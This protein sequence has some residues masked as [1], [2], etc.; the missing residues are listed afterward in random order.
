MKKDISSILSMSGSSRHAM[1]IAIFMY[2]S[3]LRIFAGNLAIDGGKTEVWKDESRSYGVLTIGTENGSG[4]LVA[5]DSTINLTDSSVSLYVGWEKSPGYEGLSASL[6]LTNTVLTCSGA[7]YL[8]YDVDDGSI[9]AEIGKGSVVTCSSV[10]RYCR[11]SSTL[12]FTG[13]SMMFN[14]TEGARIFRSRAHTWGNSW[15]NGGIDVCGEGSPI[16]I[17]IPNDRKLAEGWANRHVKF[18]GDGGLVKRGEG[19]LLWGWH[20]EGSNQGYLKGDAEYTGDTVI[21]AGGIRLATPSKEARKEVRYSIPKMSPLVIEEGAFFD[22]AGNDAAWVGVSGAG[23]LT[24]SSDAVATITLGSGNADSSFGV[25]ETIGAVN[26]VK[27]GTGTLA[28]DTREFK[29]TFTV[30]NGTLKVKNGTSISF[31]TINAVK[32]ATLDFRGATVSC[33]ELNAPVGVTVLCDSDTRFDYA[34]N[35]TDSARLVAG[36]LPKRGDFTKTGSGT[37]TVV[38]PSLK[39]DGVVNI[40]EGTV[41]CEAAQPFSGKF[42]RL[43]YSHAFEDEVQEGKDKWS[44]DNYTIQ[45]SEFSLYGVDG[46]RINKGGFSYTPITGTPTLPYGG[47][48]GIGDATMLA[49][50][51]VA[52]WMP[53]HNQ[54][55]QYAT[56]SSYDGSP[57]ALFDGNTKTKLRNTSYWDSSSIIVFRLEADATDALGFTFTTSDYPIRRPTEWVLDGSEDGI[58]WKTLAVRKADTSLSEEEKWEWR[59]NGTPDTKHTEYNNGFPYMF[60]SLAVDEAYAPFGKGVVAVSAGATLALNPSMVIEGLCID[61]AGAGNI[62]GGF[63]PAENGTLSLENV[64]NRIS[65]VVLLPLVVESVENPGRFKSWNVRVNGVAADCKVRWTSDGLA[66]SPKT[67]LR[68]IIR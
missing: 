66:V 35:S 12:L 18:L 13:G 5:S 46:N 9:L 49:E 4:S 56:S 2:F 17:E 38:G 6:I 55:F 51:E 41:V 19:T 34:L 39:T 24:N 33:A 27:I 22:F 30:S 21:K 48:D 40:K 42:F 20:T 11:P 63:T 15:P 16:D 50:R 61:M 43:K 25:A 60:S 14:G 1:I 26:A 10:T 3:G 45:F 59:L 58:E 57:L 65:G 36:A 67:R 37:L 62:T 31:G 47:Y 53:N 29:G 7:L 44:D 28:V 54:W 32:G 68:I 23:I 64:E 52:V 8:G